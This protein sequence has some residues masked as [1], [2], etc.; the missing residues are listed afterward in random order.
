LTPIVLMRV[1]SAARWLRSGGPDGRGIRTMLSV[2]L[3]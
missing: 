1:K 3:A 2:E